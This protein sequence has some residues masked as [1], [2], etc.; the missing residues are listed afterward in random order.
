MRKDSLF[1]VEREDDAD[2]RRLIRGRGIDDRRRRIDRLR[3]VIATWGLI[4]TPT[5]LVPA[6]LLIPFASTVIFAER[7]R[8]EYAADHRG[9]DERHHDPADGRTE[10]PGS[11]IRGS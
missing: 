9:A 5:L 4:H 7:R 1:N 3:V 10:F 8:D 6:V 11:R 2:A